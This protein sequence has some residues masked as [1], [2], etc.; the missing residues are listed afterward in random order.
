MTDPRGNG[1][2]IPLADS[3]LDLRRPR[4][5][6]EP[7]RR[8]FGWTVDCRRAE[9]RPA[10]LGAAGE[11]RS[12]ASRLVADLAEAWRAG[13][14]PGADEFLAR[15]PG[16]AHHPEAAPRLI[17]E[18]ILLR[19]EWGEP[20]ARDDFHRRFPLRRGVVDALLEEAGPAFPVVGEELGGVRLLAELG[21]GGAG[22]VFLAAQPALADRPI[23]VKVIARLGGEHQSLARLRHSHIVPLL[24]AQDLPGRGLRLLCMPHLGGATLADLL[25]A[26]RGLPPARRSGLALVEALDRATHAAA[27]PVAAEGPSRVILA[28]ETFERALCWIALGLARALHHAHGR[29][30]V[31]LDV[32]P[33]NVLVAADGT[34]MLLDFHLAQRALAP[35][36][37]DPEHLGGTPGRM[38]PEQEAALDDAR[39]G[40]PIGSAVDG[41]ADVFALGVLLFDGLAGEAPPEG[42][43]AASKRLGR[44]N[45]Q[46]GVGLADVVARCLEPDPARR[47]PDASALAEDLRLHLANRPLAGVRNRSPVE[48]WAKWRRRDPRA[49]LR[50]IALAPLALALGLAGL[51]AWHSAAGLRD[52][53]GEALD[54]GRLALEAGDHAGALRA[55]ELAEIRLRVDPA[56]RLLGP[57]LGAEELRREL[58]EGQARARRSG[59]LAEAHG[60]AERLR[61]AQASGPPGGE[62][63]RALASALDRF[64]KARRS[65]GRALLGGASAEERERFRL[66]LLDLAILR[67]DLVTR[68]APADRRASAIED[69]L[70]SLDEAEA[71]SGPSPALDLERMAYAKALG[72][73]DLAEQAGARLAASPPRTAWEHHALGRSR[74]AAGDLVAAALAF[75]KA[76]E[77]RPDA[78]W[79]QFDR[80]RC[81]LRR[82]RHAE[83]LDAFASCVALAPG[84]SACYRNRSLAFAGLGDRAAAARDLARAE[85]IEARPA[86]GSVVPA[87]D[88]RW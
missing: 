37:R 59:L 62:E 2:E 56:I 38:A 32:K 57:W 39:A 66:D 51:A 31:H 25:E 3:T 19:R 27:S 65:I 30:L 36:D 77:L 42:P 72:R 21:R 82:G 64:W 33:E 26:T 49:D 75:R 14:R 7:S 45:P 81:A 85:A 5:A 78:L 43:R 74:L 35:G 8:D 10:D 15:H 47:Y 76:A 11:V 71:W 18:E 23:V 63:D 88:R 9:A 69:A 58:G 28:G 52:A 68:L 79:P 83:A 70:R 55:F 60:L 73:V 4:P 44:L 24:S 54:R 53:A 1:G 61:W 50:A 34:P 22:R 41:R 40:R 12:L 17:H 80:G 20:I 87:G 13:L 46:V 16:L 6:P 29:G 67:A 86:G 48:R 84:V